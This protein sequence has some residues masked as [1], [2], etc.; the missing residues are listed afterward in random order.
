M[1]LRRWRI[2]GAISTTSH[3]STFAAYSPALNA[4]TVKT[5]FALAAA[6]NILST[7]KLVDIPQLQTIITRIIFT[8]PQVLACRGCKHARD[9]LWVHSYIQ[10]YSCQY[11]CYTH[12]TDRNFWHCYEM[13]LQTCPRVTS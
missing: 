13:T 5:I 8:P 12:N 10:Q 4:S 1:L 7:N 11:L 6:A 9:S 2:C 3:S